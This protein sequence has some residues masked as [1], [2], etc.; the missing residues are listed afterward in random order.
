MAQR[1]WQ[2]INPEEID[3]R[4]DDTVD[5]YMFE[6]GFAFKVGEWPEFLAK[7]NEEAKRWGYKGIRSFGYNPDEG[8]FVWLQK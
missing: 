3:K 2:Y 4:A 7:L 8:A 6:E 1:Y 5:L